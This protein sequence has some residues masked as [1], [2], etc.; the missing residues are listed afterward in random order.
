VAAE[1]FGHVRGAFTGA[2]HARQGLFAEADGGTLFLDEVGELPVEVQPM[3][4][5]ALERKVT[6][7]VGGARDLPH[8]VRLIAATHRNLSEEVRAG[9]FREDLYFRLCGVRVRLPPLRERPEDLPRLAD[10]FAAQLGARLPPETLAL[11]SHYAWPGNVRELRNTV[12]RLAADPEGP[13]FQAP[14]RDPVLYDHEGRL[15]PLPEARRLAREDFER[16]YLQQVLMQVGD[17]AVKC[18]EI[19]GVSR[20]LWA[21][22]M[23][24]HGMRDRRD[25]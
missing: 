11:L 5:G 3:L 24:R 23:A 22:L 10:V 13:L 25:S 17:H 14:A 15:W 19:A 18:A 8:D 20:Q 1:L 12:T 7:P 4:L 6:R 21:A 9:R 2:D 16:R